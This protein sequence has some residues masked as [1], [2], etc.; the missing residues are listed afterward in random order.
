MR[1]TR[2]L[3][4]IRL[5]TITARSYHQKMRAEDGGGDDLDFGTLLLNMALDAPPPVHV[6]DEMP[7]VR[8]PMDAIY[9]AMVAAANVGDA[10]TDVQA[11]A[12]LYADRQRR[13]RDGIAGMP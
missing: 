2:T 11:P 9:A 5:L 8:S 3:G 10:A 1:C 13:Y 12:Q 4:R 7:P 6:P